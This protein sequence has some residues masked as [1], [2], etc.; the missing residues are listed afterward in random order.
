[1]EQLPEHGTCFICRSDNPPGVGIV[2][3]GHE[4]GTITAD[5][6]YTIAQQ[7]PPGHAHGGASAAVLDEAMGAVVWF[8]GFMVV[9]ANLNIDFRRPVPLAVPVQVKSWVVAQD[10][11]K[12]TT[13]SELRLP[14]GEVAV[15]GK[16]LFV[17]APHLFTDSAFTENYAHYM[18]HMKTRQK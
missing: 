5:F 2:L 1:M 13:Q 16:G 6:T 12:V 15:A 3:F 9:V 10:G 4:D 18:A 8:N 11:R 7:G 17:E 14:G